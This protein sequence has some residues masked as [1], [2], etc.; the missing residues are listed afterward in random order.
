MN[1]TIINF[2]FLCFHDIFQDMMDNSTAMIKN[3]TMLI[4][5][6]I[7]QIANNSDKISN[8]VA[9]IAANAA[10]IASNDDEIAANWV[11]D[12]IKVENSIAENADDVAVINKSDEKVLDD[13][14][15]LNEIEVKSE[16]SDVNNSL[17]KSEAKPSAQKEANDQSLNCQEEIHER[18]KLKL[19]VKLNL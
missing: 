1:K 6:N 15:F 18:E 5:D 2:N 12:N 16:V 17:N 9:D 19:I 13:F 10:D 14:P 11:A 3:N 8:N 7:D 4:E